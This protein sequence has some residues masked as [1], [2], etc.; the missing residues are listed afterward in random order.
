MIVEHRMYLPLAAVLAVAV[1]LAGTAIRRWPR[2]RAA[3]LGGFGAAALGC[4][5]LT[6]QRNADYRD[7]VGL[8]TKTVAQRP[9]NVLARTLLAD[10]LVGAG[11][12]DAATAQVQAALA[13]EPQ[14]GLA[15][16]VLGKIRFRQGRWDDAI[17]QYRAAVAA[18]PGSL[19]AHDNLGLAL[20]HEGRLT[21]A[22]AEL[23]WAIR[24]QPGYAAA[25]YN[26]SRVLKALGHAEPSREQYAE[27][28]R[29][30]PDQ[31]FGPP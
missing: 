15:H 23:H 31:A 24:I 14:F 3:W 1:G 9:G 17:A 18:R 7:A 10:T 29:L 25:H 11:N 13:I 16:E 5:A 28:V 19:D 20:E 8:W 30:D 27:A 12:L 26:A 4:V 21:E 2:S 6:I 22:L